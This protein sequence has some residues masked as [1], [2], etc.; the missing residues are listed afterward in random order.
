MAGKSIKAFG[1]AER[2][3]H[4]L[5]AAVFFA[6][7]LT[8]LVLYVP[9]LSMTV[10]V[11][12]PGQMVRYLHRVFAILFMAVP[13]IFLIVDAVESG[14]KE[15]AITMKKIFTWGPDDAKWLGAAFAYYF[16]GDESKM[17]P[18]DKFNTGQKLFYVLNVF[19]Y[20]IWVVTGLIM[21]F[22]KGSVSVGLF[23]W[24]V[25]LHDLAVI[26]V[27]GFFLIHFYLSTFH[28][29]MKDSLD[30]MRFGTLPEEYVKEHH[31]KWYEEV[32]GS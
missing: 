12:G 2:L 8:G 1:L 15:F 29:L 17:P 5:H 13:V 30:S 6:L 11:G 25:F 31:A 28:P 10:G 18:Q 26:V 4:W 16:N 20:I 3:G 14:L 23:Q 27:G 22:G 7:L 9:T 32:K 19:G 24:S 21:W